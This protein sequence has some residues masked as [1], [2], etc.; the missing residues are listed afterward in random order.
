MTDQLRNPSSSSSSSSASPSSSLASAP[1]LCVNRCGFYGSPKQDDLCSKCYKAIA[2]SKAQQAAA[3]A[4]AA[5][6][7]PAPSDTLLHVPVPESSSL[8]SLPS[9][10]SPLAIPLLTHSGRHLSEESPA[11]LDTPVESVHAFSSPLPL[12]APALSFSESLTIPLTSPQSSPA[13]SSTPS[14]ESPVLPL[15]DLSLSPFSAPAPSPAPLPVPASVVLPT[16][17]PPSEPAKK[18]K[19]RCSH[20][21]KLVGLTYFACRCNEEAMFCSQHRYPHS[22]G[23]QFDHRAQQ[24]TKLT[25]NNPLCAHEKMEK[26]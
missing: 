17:A 23:C 7:T 22:H 11:V 15:A 4:A 25:K 5:I 8:S 3:A 13:L 18:R 16:S 6:A 12:S 1:S 19:N 24:Q 21:A 20:C 26:I 2:Q 10:P 9:P 14:V